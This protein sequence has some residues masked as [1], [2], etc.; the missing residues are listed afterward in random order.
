VLVQGETG[1]GKELIAHAIHQNSRRRTKEFV[2]INCGAI[3]K[4][5]VESE[6]FGYTRGAFTG[7][8]SNK[9]GRIEA[10]DGG[11]LFLDE[12][13][14]AAARCPGKLLRVLQEGELPKV[15]A[16]SPIR[17]DIA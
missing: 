15:G 2:P 12:V 10:A 13:G 1:T 9:P 7:A 14:R 4:D 8:L 3:P 16:S 17:V 11:T 5:L 6:L